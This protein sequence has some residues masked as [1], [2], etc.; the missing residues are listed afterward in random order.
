MKTILSKILPFVERNGEFPDDKMEI[1]DELLD[2]VFPAGKHKNRTFENVLG[3]EIEDNLGYCIWYANQNTS[4]GK[5]LKLTPFLINLTFI[6][7]GRKHHKRAKAEIEQEERRMEYCLQNGINY[8]LDYE[9]RH[10]RNLRDW[11]M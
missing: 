5:E 9:I 8:S 6:A 7:R 1:V 4:S 3:D 11:G 2:Y 10:N